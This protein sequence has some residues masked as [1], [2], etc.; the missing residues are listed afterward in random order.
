MIFLGLG[1]GW[2]KEL[3]DFLKGIDDLRD[4]KEEEVG[5]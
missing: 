1:K 5:S 2:E 3:P 4:Q